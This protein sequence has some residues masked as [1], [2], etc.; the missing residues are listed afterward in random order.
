QGRCRD[1]FAG[2]HVYRT[3]TDL[4][5][6]RVVAAALARRV[7]EAHFPDPTATH[8]P[9]S[10]PVNDPTPKSHQ[11][12][13]DKNGGAPVPVQIPQATGVQLD[14]QI[15]EI[16]KQ[17]RQLEKKFNEMKF[18]CRSSLEKRNVPVKKVVDALTNLPADDV[19]E[20]RQI[21]QGQLSVFY[22]ATD[23]AELIG[24]L[25]FNM[26]YLSYHLLEYVMKEFDMDHVKP[27]METYKSDLQQ[28]RKRTPLTLF[29]R[30]LKK[31]KIKL[32]PEFQ[33]LVAEFD[34]PESVTLEVVEQFRQEYASHYNLRECAM[35][36][37]HIRPGS[38]IITWFI[39]E[40]VVE[41]LK[42]NVPKAILKRYLVIK[43]VIAGSCVHR[44]RKP[45]ETLPVTPST[46]SGPASA[47]SI[48]ATGLAVSGAKP[49]VGQPKPS[50]EEDYLF[51]EEP[52]VDF[53]CPVT[54]G[55]LL[56]PHLTSCCG[57]HLSEEAA[58]RIKKEGRACPHCNTSPWS[59]M[60]DKHFQRKVN[61]LSV[62]CCHEDRGCWWIGEL[63]AF[64]NHVLCCPMSN[65]TLVMELVKPPLYGGGATVRVES[66]L[67]DVD[68]SYNTQL[69]K[70]PTASIPAPT[71][72]PGEVTSVELV[73]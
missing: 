69:D 70:L 47:A 50:P 54:Y 5:W 13:L 28:F 23:H 43:L 17:I 67:K 35:M 40:S 59:V 1:S 72:K 56:Q 45:Q 64:H 48:G 3:N 61:S 62:F 9:A 22:Q 30:A 19:E 21:L 24:Q 46:S 44:L 16:G 49:S 12:I 27:K 55:L 20:H 33:E 18:E 11:L 6:E 60:L 63:A 10:A 73:A 39:P 7:E 38:F 68:H 4:S 29:C 57:K 42:K 71:V 32:S 15:Q 2:N 26:N 58:T 66:F 53:F 14:A 31:K 34:W 8:T 25:S 65:A 36:I 37:A 52:S 41:K 51:V